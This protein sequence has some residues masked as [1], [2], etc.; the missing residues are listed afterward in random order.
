MGD[1]RKNLDNDWWFHITGK[2]NKNRS[3]KTVCDDML[4]ALKRYRKQLR[5]PQ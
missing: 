1:F 3:I 4:K 2:G 5:L